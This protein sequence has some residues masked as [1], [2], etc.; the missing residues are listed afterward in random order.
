MDKG[1]DSVIR[2]IDQTMQKSLL[3]DFKNYLKLNNHDKF[4][5][6]SD[7]CLEDKSKPNKIA[8]FTVAPAWTAFPAI[9]NKIQIAIPNDIKNRSFIS[10]ETIELLQDKSFFHINFILKETAGLIS[11]KDMTDQEVA[12]KSL[13]EVIK[14]IEGWIVNQPE[15][16]DKFREQIN[17]FINWRRELQKKSPNLKLYRHIV[18]ISLLASYIAHML[19]V[20]AK[21]DTVIWFADRDKITEAYSSVAFDLFEMNHYGLCDYK[22]VDGSITELGLGIKDEGSNEL[23]YDPLIRIPDYLAGTLSSWN[24]SANDV[25]KS[26]HAQILQKVFSENEFCAIIVINLGKDKYNCGRHTISP[27]ETL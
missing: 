20:E 14:I 18:L 7:Y 24:M 2:V 10:D 27:L 15:G 26:K 13:G 9:I 8:S 21:A 4:V 16:E 19:T 1:I 11:R 17:R 22:G 12:L 25:S 5:I 6:Y 3:Q 23:W